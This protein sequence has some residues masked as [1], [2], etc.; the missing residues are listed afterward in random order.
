[1]VSVPKFIGRQIRRVGD[2]VAGLARAAGSFVDEHRPA[3][4]PEPR[5]LAEIQAELDSLVGLDSVKEQV[6][7]LIAL[8]KMQQQRQDAGLHDVSTA[9]HLVLLG[10]P[11]TGK[12]TVARLIAEMYGSIGLLAVGHL[13][14]VDR[15]G[16]VGQY[17]GQTAVK[18]NRAIRKAIGGVLFID[19]AYGLSRASGM[20]LDYG[21]EAIETLVKRM[22]DHRD[23][24]VV[25]VAGYPD[26]MHRFLDSNP[27]LRSRFSR[28]IEFPDYTTDELVRIIRSMATD[29]DYS[30]ADD[31]DATLVEIFDKARAGGSFGNGR[32]ARNL[33]EQALTRHAL[34]L[35]DAPDGEL[36]RDT[37]STLTIDDLTRAAE[38]LR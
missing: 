2:D 27:G 22:E 8:L 11:G 5:P 7:S 6:R 35:A 33:F 4:R 26:L 37:L 29:A 18:T 21:A 14:E 31:A 28:E 3:R 12:T 30:I 17:V 16:L 32:Y 19:E 34:R 13:V 9:Q 25:I 23:E 38:R 1:M 15:G 20:P 24:L 10:N 36:D